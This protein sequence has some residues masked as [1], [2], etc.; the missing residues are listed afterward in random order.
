MLV[1]Q[2]SFVLPPLLLT[3]LYGKTAYAQRKYIWYYAIKFSKNY[4]TSENIQLT[5]ESFHIA[6]IR[7]QISNLWNGPTQI[8]KKEFM[9]PFRY[10]FWDFSVVITF[11]QQKMNVNWNVKSTN[12]AEAYEFLDANYWQTIVHRFLDVDLLALI[13]QSHRIGKTVHVMDIVAWKKSF[14]V[15]QFVWRIDLAQVLIKIE[16]F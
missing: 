11:F 4:K 14:Q 16:Y 5:W 15:S 2:M 1:V 13:G 12:G 9:D 6:N 8:V 10:P 7:F 3:I